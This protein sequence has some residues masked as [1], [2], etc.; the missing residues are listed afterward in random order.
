M[1]CG[2]FDRMAKTI[3]DAAIPSAL[4]REGVCGCFI[5]FKPCHEDLVQNL[6]GL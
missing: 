2:Y 1:A 6:G 3:S 5:A 4:S